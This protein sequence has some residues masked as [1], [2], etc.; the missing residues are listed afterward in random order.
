[1][2]IKLFLVAILCSMALLTACT[3]EKTTQT[4][5]PAPESDETPKEQSDSTEEDTTETTTEENTE[6]E[7]DKTEKPKDESDAEKET[8]TAEKE[9]NDSTEEDTPTTTPEDKP[10][11][12]KELADFYYEKLELG[13]PK[14]EATTLLG[15]TYEEGFEDLSGDPTINYSLGFNQEILPPDSSNK[16]DFLKL[17]EGTSML[18][19]SLAI[20]EDKVSSIHVS[21]FNESDN[22]FVFLME[23]YDYENGGDGNPY[24]KTER[25]KAEHVLQ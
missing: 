10:K 21:Y 12:P 3:E 5:E 25:V 1:M 9:S 8:P 22:K 13:M 14:K 4:E 23:F 6:K 16:S 24:Q 18:H 19:I 7:T 2:H 17:Y 11:S 15:N 20:D